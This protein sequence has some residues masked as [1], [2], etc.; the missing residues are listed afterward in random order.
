MD[1]KQYMFIIKDEIKDNVISYNNNDKTKR[2]EITY[3]KGKTYSYNYS[4]VKIIK[5][6]S[7][8]DLRHY[9]FTTQ[10]GKVLNNISEA[11]EFKSVYK[12]YLRF[13]F[14]N[15]TFKSYKENELVIC[16]NALDNNSV[17]GLFEYLKKAAYCNNLQTD[18]GERILGNIYDKIE[19]ISDESVFAIYLNDGSV[20]K[21]MNGN[22]WRFAP[23][24]DK[25]QKYEKSAPKS[26]NWN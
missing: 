3:N 26:I 1:P 8:I 19:F 16:S 7:P 10:K 21:Y 9:Q 17:N 5:D 4:D 24:C 14:N 20:K 23:T 2:M 15:G 18:E 6:P 22:K 11:Y 12:T 13:F 25:M